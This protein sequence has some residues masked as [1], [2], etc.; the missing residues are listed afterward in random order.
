[1]GL[2]S[3]P[4]TP[5]QRV[6]A[7]CHALAGDGGPHAG[8][9]AAFPPRRSRRA[10]PPWRSRHGRLLHHGAAGEGGIGAQ[11]TCAETTG[12]DLLR[13]LSQPARG[14]ARGTQVRTSYLGKS[15]QQT[16]PQWIA[17]PKY[18]ACRV[19]SAR[20]CNELSVVYTLLSSTKNQRVI[21]LRERD[22]GAFKLEY[23]DFVRM[24][25]HATSTRV[26]DG[27]DGAMHRAE[28]DARVSNPCTD[29][30]G[31]CSA[32]NRRRPRARARPAPAVLTSSGR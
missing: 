17:L 27:P 32:C 31:A 6:V 2:P 3:R 16:W 25:W 30:A 1:M 21:E 10:Q 7:G 26:Y 11:A 12:E 13:M 18:Y 24:P 14:E 15:L 4:C 19:W 5:F 9:M 28:A 8:T 20:Q 29:G 23:A 22:A